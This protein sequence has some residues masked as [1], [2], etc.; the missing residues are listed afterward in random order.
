MA[1]PTLP[2]TG[3]PGG[4]PEVV[5]VLRD[6]RAALDAREGALMDEMGRRWLAVEQGLRSDML[7]LAYEMETR[8]AEGKVITEQ[9]VWR[10]ERYQV[11]QKQ[12]ET[13][14]RSYNRDAAHLVTRAQEED[15]AL[16]ILAAQQAI[17]V[18]IAASGMAG[19]MWNRINT[20]AVQAMIGLA[21][22]GS[23]LYTLLKEDYPA[24][25]DGIVGSL[26]NGIARGQGVAQTALDMADGMAN[27]LDRA[28]LI[29]RTETARAYRM[30]STQQ[31][32]DSG[33]VTG[34]YRLVKKATACMACLVLDGQHYDLEAEM[35]D[36]PRGKCMVVPEVIGVGKPRWESGIDYFKNLTPE[37]Q[38]ERMGQEKYKLWQDGQFALKDLAKMQHDPTWGAAPRIAT[39]VELKQ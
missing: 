29:A 38:A 5:R 35:E 8:R 36:H 4:D 28:M 19:P 26:I 7:A 16:G 6:Y 10:A 39:I 2:S 21:G 9:M 24:A 12:L 31:Y 11:V 23:P 34:F 15:A 13:Q 22:D 18:S 25:L 30:G 37:Q 20:N 3:H 32:R 1:I 14:I 17:H 27:G 33:V